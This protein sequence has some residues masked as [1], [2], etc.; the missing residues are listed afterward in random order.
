M[1]L[2]P[3]NNSSMATDI[4]N[5][6]ESK[7]RLEEIIANLGKCPRDPEAMRK[8]AERMDQAREETFNR[9]GLLDVAVPF[10]RELRDR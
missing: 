8:A 4:T 10:I 3:F 6:E 1:T 9:V 7:H 5:T 2:V